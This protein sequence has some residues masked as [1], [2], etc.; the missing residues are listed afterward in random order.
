[1]LSASRLS[2]LFL[3]LLGLCASATLP[4][5]QP[6]LRITQLQRCGDLLAE[7]PSNWCLQASSP[8]DEDVRVLLA[9]QPLRAEQLEHEGARL[10]LTLPAGQASAPLWLEREGQRSNPVWLSRGRSQVLAA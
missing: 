7:G 4:A 6:E 10:R 3:G 5:A 1:M 9:G 8:L 2:G